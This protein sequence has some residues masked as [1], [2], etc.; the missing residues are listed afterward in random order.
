VH[1]DRT[2]WF[3]DGGARPNPGPIETA[4]VSRGRVWM[5]DGLGPGDNNEAEWLALLHALD[6]A[7][8]AGERDVLFA[9]DSR[10]VIA[11]ASGQQPC[12]SPHLAPYLAEFRARSGAIPVVRLRHVPRSKNL[13]G[14]ALARQGLLGSTQ[15]R[16]P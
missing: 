13:A 12:R 16:L 5:R 7:I 4:V 1:G 8:A 2:V 9:G 14:I 15:S 11:Q 6:L 3:F 10:L